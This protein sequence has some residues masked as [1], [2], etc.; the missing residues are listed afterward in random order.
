MPERPIGRAL[1]SSSWGPGEDPGV[2]RY[3]PWPVICLCRWIT[4]NTPL[5]VLFM[6][7]DWYLKQC[8][9]G[10]PTAIGVQHLALLCN[11]TVPGQHKEPH[12]EPSPHT[13]FFADVLL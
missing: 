10:R 7:S 3:Q 13:I 12:K 5:I 6:M 4:F 2:G 8:R 11:A 1:D 9:Q